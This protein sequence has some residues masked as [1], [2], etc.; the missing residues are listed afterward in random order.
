MPSSVARTRCS[1]VATGKLFEYLGA[2]RPILVLGD[3]TAAAEIVRSAVAGIVASATDPDEIAAALERLVTKPPAP[4]KPKA[5]AA[6]A[7]PAVA[8]RLAALID[9]VSR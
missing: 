8:E 7:F 6:Y 2:R 1:S 9:E 4:P 3:G 5:V